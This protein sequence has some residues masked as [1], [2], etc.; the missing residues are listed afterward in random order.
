MVQPTLQFIKKYLALPHYDYD[1][2]QAY[3]ESP[4]QAIEV[5]KPNVSLVHLKQTQ[6]LEGRKGPAHGFKRHSKIATNLGA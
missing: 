1:S 3:F 2:M 6:L 5:N 4:P